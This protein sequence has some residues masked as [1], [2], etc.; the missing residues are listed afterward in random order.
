MHSPASIQHG[1]T[2]GP[3]QP[4]MDP[5]PRTRKRSPEETTSARF[6]SFAFP[7][8]GG[9]GD[10]REF[11]RLSTQQTADSTT[12]CGGSEPDH[13][14]LRFRESRPGAAGRGSPDA[15]SSPDERS[16]D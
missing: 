3:P 9:H 14:E 12:D 2:G 4:E 11:I 6:M 7:P 13:R 15:P 16:A 1:M 8:P 5:A 10:G